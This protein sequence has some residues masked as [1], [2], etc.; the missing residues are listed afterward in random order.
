MSKIES[1][2]LLDWTARV[3]ELENPVPRLW[4]YPAC[5]NGWDLA[6]QNGSAWFGTLERL[7]SLAAWLRR[8]PGTTLS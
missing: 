5:L 1:I 4:T 6:R 3:V 2:H 7:F 8:W